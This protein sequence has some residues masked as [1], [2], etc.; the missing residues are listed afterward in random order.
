ML[1]G[2]DGEVLRTQ[3]HIQEGQGL[4]GSMPGPVDRRKMKG[5]TAKKKGLQRATRLF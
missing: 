4:G 3:G 5:P 1:R 2:G